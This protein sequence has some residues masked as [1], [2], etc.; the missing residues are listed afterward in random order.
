VVEIA[1]EAKQ[2]AALLAVE[3][4]VEVVDGERHRWLCRWA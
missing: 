2:L 4:R 3:R 1:D